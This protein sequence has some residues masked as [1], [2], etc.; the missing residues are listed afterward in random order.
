MLNKMNLITMIDVMTGLTNEEYQ[1]LLS[2]SEE[3]IE[4]IYINYYQQ[5]DDEQIEICYF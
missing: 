2:K 3:G 4:K 5:Q 1:L